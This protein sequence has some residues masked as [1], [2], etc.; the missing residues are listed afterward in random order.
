MSKIVFIR[1]LRVM[2]DKDLAE[3][4]G[5]K[6]IRLREQVKRNSVRFPETFMFQLD[7]Q[8]VQLLVSQNAI[9]GHQS[10]GGTRPYVFTEHGILMLANVL[11]SQQAI[12]MS[13]KIIEIFVQ[14]REYLLS[15]K[16]LL[17]KLE[18][19]ENIAMKHEADI[20]LIFEYIKQLIA[21]PKK[22]LKRI[23][24]RLPGESD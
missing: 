22:E 8:E 2:I 6:P 18:Q 9:A 20:Q 3:I 23:G 10:L 14:L 5:V 4:Y 21:T 13:I 16:E 15:N 24:Y 12:Q 7:K 11:K 17:L 19:L 1:G